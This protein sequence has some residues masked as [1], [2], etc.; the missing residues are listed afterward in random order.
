MLLS[1]TCENLGGPDTGNTTSQIIWSI[2]ERSWMEVTRVQELN[3]EQFGDLLHHVILLLKT[4]TGLLKTNPE[5]TQ[6][7]A[8]IISS[9]MFIEFLGRFI[10]SPLLIA[11]RASHAIGLVNQIHTCIDMLGGRGSGRGLQLGDVIHLFPSSISPS[12]Y[13][14]PSLANVN[15]IPGSSAPWPVAWF[16]DPNVPG[17]GPK[18]E[19]AKYIYQG[20]TEQTGPGP[21]GTPWT[22]ENPNTGESTS[23]TTERTTL[24]KLFPPQKPLPPVFHAKK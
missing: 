4:I 24:E 8:E 16:R 2:L 13:T 11:T 23:A 15:N 14:M 5:H 17:N 6:Y 12:Y 21:A 7:V 19:L 3:P 18:P 20:E 22:P 9:D 1:Y 10:L